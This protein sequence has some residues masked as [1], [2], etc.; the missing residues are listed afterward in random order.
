M[1]LRII[2]G[3]CVTAL[4]VLVIISGKEIFDF[5]CLLL[6]LVAV[7]EIFNA[8][9]AK[10]FKPVYVAGYIACACVF[11][12]SIEYWDRR[13]WGWLRSIIL[14]VDIRFLLYLS[15]LLMF[16]FL[17]L[18][19]NRHTVADLAVTILGAFYIC[20][21]FWYLIMTRNLRA[22]EYAVMFVLLA[23][24]ATDTAAYFVGTL[25]GKHKLI[26]EVSAKKTVEGAIA[27]VIACMVV[28]SLY[29]ELVYNRITGPNPIWQYVLFGLACGIVAQIGD[30]AASCIKR[31]CGIKD[32]GKII[33]GHGG[34][35]DR[36]DS[37]I[38]LSP[39]IHIMLT[40]MEKVP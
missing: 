37:V 32:F 22:G 27:G 14:F 15:L 16:V 25:F 4:V 35:L 5:A 10:G 13:V 23:A 34:I 20:F 17:I 40:V 12:G 11:L 2:S 30:L 1:K 6:A 33:P 38:L 19:I 8:F 24:L 21:L 31:Y 18:G 3:V 26:P 28:I 39:L 7:H 29:G 9:S 36:M